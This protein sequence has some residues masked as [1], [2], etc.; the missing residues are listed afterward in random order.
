MALSK[1]P[2]AVGSGGTPSVG[3]FGSD[4][5]DVT[6]ANGVNWGFNAKIVV[7]DLVTSYKHEVIWDL[8]NQQVWVRR[9]DWNAWQLRTT[10]PFA[11]TATPTG[12][13]I[14]ES[15][16]SVTFLIP[17]DVDFPTSMS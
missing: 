8:V 12:M 5:N 4:A 11:F 15:G 14:T 2:C 10:T 6:S 7:S 16:A 1:M 17:L 9:Q 3:Y 13:K